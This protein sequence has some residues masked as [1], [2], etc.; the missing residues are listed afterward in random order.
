MTQPLAALLAAHP[1][2]SVDGDKHERG[3]AVIVAGSLE[4]PGGAR[5]AA[6]AA[7]RVGAGT[8][9]VVMP[10]ELTVALGVAVPEAL[11]VGW[12]HEE[13]PT[14]RVKE[15]V[16]RADAVLIGPGL[17]P[18]AGSIARAVG[19][20]I[21]SETAVLLDAQALSAAGDLREHRLVLL[22]N[23]DEAA[24]ILDGDVGE[25]L[26]DVAQHLA[27]TYGATVAVRG[28]DTAVSSGGDVWR[29]AGHPGLGTSGSGDVLAGAAAGLTARGVAPLPA[30]GWAVAAHAAAG[31]LVAGAQRSPGYG[32]LARELVDAL[33]AALSRAGAPCADT[34]GS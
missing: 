28:E 30:L 24:E 4:C 12:A 33:P 3:T 15:V 5:L 2:P 13:P 20:H 25:D 16:G 11:V 17:G 27:E 6:T 29:S 14:E 32:Y 26:A 19:Q 31:E 34:P 10:P 21:G 1:L 23:A 8:V 7:L 22:P 18:D 9:Q